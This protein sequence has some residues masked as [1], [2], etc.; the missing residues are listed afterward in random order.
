VGEGETQLFL[1]TANGR[2]FPSR[3]CAA[4]VSRRAG[5]SASRRSWTRPRARRRRIPWP[6]IGSPVSPR[7]AAAGQPSGSPADRRAPQ[8]TMRWC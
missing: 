8:R 6:G 1:A 4:R 2:R 7:A 5:A 3:S